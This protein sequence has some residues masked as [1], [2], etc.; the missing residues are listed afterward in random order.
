MLLA[1]VFMF[2]NNWVSQRRSTYHQYNNFLKVNEI[3]IFLIFVV[4]FYII[5]L[6]FIIV[7]VFFYKCTSKI[8]IF[9]FAFI[10]FIKSCFKVFLRKNNACNKKISK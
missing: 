5:F 8:L 7:I 6:K 3:F 1:F 9:C 2:E 10:F 4:F